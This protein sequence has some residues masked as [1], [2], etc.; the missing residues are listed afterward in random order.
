MYIYLLNF[1]FAISTTIGM[2]IIP[3]L[4]TENLG[5]SLLILGLIEGSSELLSNILRLVTGN[6]FDRIKNKRALFIVPAI[7]TFFSKTLLFLPHSLTIFIS[8]LLERISNG[9][10]AAPRDAYV[11]Q[12]AKNKGMAFSLMTISKTAGCIVGPMIVSLST[13]LLGSLQENIIS[14]IAVACFLNFLA[15]GV[16]F[17]IRSK[18]EISISPKEKLDFSKYKEA[19]K[20]VRALFVLA[21]LFFMARF[22]DGLIMIHLKQQGFPEYFYLSTISFFNVIMLICSPIYGFVIDRGKHYHALII[23]ILSLIMFNVAFLNMQ[24]SPWILACL[25]IT[26]WGIQRVGAQIT[27]TV[28][29]L[30]N[31]DKKF[32]GTAVGLFA[33]ISGFGT[34]LSSLMSGYLADYDFNNVFI[35]SLIFAILSFLV[36]IKIIRDQ[37][38][39]AQ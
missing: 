25:G 15:I 18:K 12:N 2:T 6:L 10:F 31:I 29:L 3:L 36:A 1:I 17:L 11:G 21:L 26:F 13:I 39:I 37:K 27:F 4:V 22:N 35:Y 33:V 14:I 32:Y 9:A 5:I 16:S 8:K 28:L 24:L 23:T 34:F 38:I 19:F 20:S 7:I 30:K